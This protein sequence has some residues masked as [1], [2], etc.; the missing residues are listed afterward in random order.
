[1]TQHNLTWNYQIYKLT[2]YNIPVT[3]FFFMFP[4]KKVQTKKQ[5]IKNKM[6]TQK[7]DSFF[8]EEKNIEE[9]SVDADPYFDHQISW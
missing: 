5:Q 9:W 4:K 1:M 7:Y 6:N 8:F 2:L 3:I